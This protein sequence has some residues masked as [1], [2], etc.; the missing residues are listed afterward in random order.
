MNLMKN[1]IRII[2][3]LG[4]SIFFLANVVYASR[5]TNSY[6][7]NIFPI[8]AGNG[9]L[10]PPPN[11]LSSSLENKRTSVII[12]YLDDSA[13]S[14]EF[15]PVVSGLKLL[16]KSSID[17]LPITTDELQG[18]Q[19]T[20]PKQESYYWH[21][22]IPQIVVINGQ[23][24][25][26]LDQEGQVPIETINKAISAASGLQEPEFSI[27]IKTLNEYNSEPEKEGYTNPR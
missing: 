20:N 23:G 17:L 12:F 13:T 2:F 22:N 6:D 10:V 1:L 3:I 18:K 26:I 5:E 11:T 16:W 7:G 4:L 19:S 15:A 9:S 24:E 14:K 25:I 8:Y 27:T 21:G